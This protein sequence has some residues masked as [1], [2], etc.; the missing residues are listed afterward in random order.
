MLASKVCVEFVVAYWYSTDLESTLI[1][2]KVIKGGFLYNLRF[3]KPGGIAN[4]DKESSN[5]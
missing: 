5:L 2:S 1:D 4:R 3:Q